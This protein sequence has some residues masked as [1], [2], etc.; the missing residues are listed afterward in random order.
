MFWHR[1][2]TGFKC[3]YFQRNVYIDSRIQRD[4]RK[5]RLLLNKN[6]TILKFEEHID[7]GNGGS[8]L[9]A[10]RIYTSPNNAGKMYKDE[11]NSEGKTVAKLE[12]MT[13]TT[14]TAKITRQTRGKE[15]V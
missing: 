6:T 11:K 4:V 8:Y 12:E 2:H 1:I 3:K 7:H 14:A 15:E 13:R 9:L 5:K 10:A